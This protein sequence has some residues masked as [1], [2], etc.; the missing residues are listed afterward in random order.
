MPGTLPLRAPHLGVRVLSLDGGGAGALSELLILERMMYR[1]K[2]EG[3]LDSVPSPCDCFEV[4]GGS[5][6]GGIIALMLGRLRMSV[7]DTVSAYEKIRPQA[8]IG[9]TEEF[10]ATQL[11]EVLKDIF[12][13][14]TMRDVRPDACKTFVCAMNE[15]N[16]NAGIPELFRSYDTAEEP[17]NDC[18]VWEAARATSAAP[19]LFKAMEIGVGGMKQQ[20]IDGG[21]GHNNPTSLVL[22]EA[23]DIYPSRPVVLVTSIGSG[24]PDT[25]QIPKSPSSTLIAAA[26]KKIATDCEKTHEDNA[27]KFRAIPNT[28]FRFNVQQGMQDLAP[29]DW[30]KSSE[31]SAHTKAYLRTEDVKSKITDSV[32]VIL[33]PAI[34]VFDSVYLKVC[35]PPTL[36][37][38]GREGILR[39]MTE[40]FNTDVG[41]RHIFLLHGLGGAGKRQIAFKF[42]EQSYIPGPRFSDIYFIDSSSQQTIEND[43][44]TIALNKGVGTTVRESLLC[45]SHQRTEWLIVFNN[46]DD[47]HFKLSH[48]LPSCFHGNVIITSRDKTLCQL[49]GAEHKVDRMELEEATDLLLSVAGCDIMAAED[50]ELGKQLVQKLHC[51]PL[52][53]AQAGAYINSLQSLQKYLRLYETTAQRIQL[54]NRAPPNLEAY[55]LSVYTTWQISFDRLSN[56]AAELLRLCFFIHHDTITEEIFQQAASYSLVPEGP[57]EEDLHEP[58]QFLGTF[59]D[60]TS[61][62]DSLKFICLTDELGRYSLIESA[63]SP[64]A[65]TFSIHPLVHEWCRTVNSDA[66]TA[67]CVH[68]VVGMSMSSAKGNFRLQH[69]IFPHLDAL[70]FRY[71]GQS[72]R[73]PSPQDMA[74]ARDFLSAYYE[75]GKWEDGIQLAKSMLETESLQRADLK[76]VA[77]QGAL[78][79]MY[80]EMGQLHRAQELE[81]LVLKRRTELLG[82]DHADT[83]SAMAN[84]A[85]TYYNL[86]QFR[87]AG[88]L[89][90]KVLNNRRNILGEDHPS[91]LGS[92]A[93]LAVTYC[94]LT[95]FQQ[96]E[97]LQTTVLNKRRNILGED[98][99]DTLSGMA[100]LAVTYS[101]LGKIRR[102]EELNKMVLKKC[103]EVLGEDH[104]DTV[105]AMANLAV[106]YSRLGQFKQAEELQTTAF[107]KRR[108]ILG[109]DHPATLRSL[110][111]LAGNYLQ[112]GQMMRA[113]ARGG[114]PKE[115]RY[116]AP[117]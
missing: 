58:R 15:M 93:N 34:Q 113:G 24:H 72:A 103:R 89:E 76:T 111:N 79:A 92:M 81:V 23:K 60:S 108:V 9:F 110:D 43:L 13:R 1:A 10:R 66:S 2:T 117:L 49:A 85:I 109:E 65:I 25:I 3:Q 51:L 77:I 68:K 115:P 55:E 84:L 74:F 105:D 37:F 39:K 97:G 19:G 70:L 48:Y 102:A 27:R 78:A 83:L 95:Q 96:A 46:A 114:R 116:H 52:A 94:S 11:E 7:A 8:K 47:N 62:W 21:V 38:T 4:I 12:K 5:G 56:R 54:L 91:T 67:V 20:F 53:V 88:D 107:S 73:Q 18:M 50:R 14:E 61:E 26:M 106:T 29:H 40:Y 33:N 100:N 63:A 35:P 42:V 71:P 86:G 90:I 17:A 98:H 36:C 16:M 87:Q 69:Q 31:V 101:Q 99:P 44:I 32:K 80:C 59:L 82:E 45:L 112:L 28:Y 64:R 104:L 75:E 30:G 6:T 22:A 41:R 57:S